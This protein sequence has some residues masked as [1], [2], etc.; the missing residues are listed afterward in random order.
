MDS[1]AIS[2]SRFLMARATNF[3]HPCCNFFFDADVHKSTLANKHLILMTQSQKDVKL[4]CDL[5]SSWE[6]GREKDE[7]RKE[8]LQGSWADTTEKAAPHLAMNAKAH[9]ESRPDGR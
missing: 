4:H 8:G 9:T 5:K 7:G 1:I 2:G 3:F 6:E